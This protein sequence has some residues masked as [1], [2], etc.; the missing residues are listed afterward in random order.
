MTLARAL[1]ALAAL[2][3][4]AV[5]AS[6]PVCIVGAGPAGLTVASQLQGK[7]Y[8]TMIF[9]KNAKVSGKCQ[10]YYDD[11]KLFHPMGALLYS[12]KTY[13]NTLPI[14]ESS[15]VPSMLFAYVNP[16]WIYDWK[17]RETTGLNFTFPKL[18]T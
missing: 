5:V 10:A 11:K 18:T 13:V 14:I 6:N 15:G 16:L 4:P 8:N 12:N 17:T 2:A 3:T 7:G 9:D 1:L